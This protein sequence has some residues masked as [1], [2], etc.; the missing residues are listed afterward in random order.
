MPNAVSDLEYD[1]ASASARISAVAALAALAVAMGIGRF[2]FTPILPM[3]QDDY[4]LTVSEAGWLASANYMGY[5]VGALSAIGMRIQ[6]TV[7]IRTGLLV[8]GLATVAMGLEYGFPL[9]VILR[10]MAGIASAWVLVFASAWALERLALAGR[11]DL[12]GVAYAGVGTGI[13]IA[14]SVCLVVTALHARSAGAWLALGV[15]SIAVTALIWPLVRSR[16]SR[17]PIAAPTTAASAIRSKEFWRLILC[18]G[19]FGFGYIIPA[20]FLPLM[21][22]TIIPDPQLFGWAW[23]VFGAAAIISTLFAARLNQ[24]LSRRVVWIVGHLVMAL[25]V[26]IPLIVSGLLGIMM[27]AL[28]VGGTF[29]VITMAGMQEARRVA[30]ARARALMAAMTSAF[31]LGQLLGP[32]AVGFLVQ[33]T[34][35]FGPVLMLA[36]AIL[37]LSAISLMSFDANKGDRT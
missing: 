20:T 22:K 37:V 25:G 10:G 32:I 4:G 2:A 5:L 18:Y 1:P 19:A 35:G 14:G 16:P 3:M 13:V 31:A 36:A 28:L 34:G 23:P 27:A 15:I 26:V 12:G 33:A 8:I 6:P 9:W 24:S 21:A 7:A 17:N 11:P 30:G 29:M